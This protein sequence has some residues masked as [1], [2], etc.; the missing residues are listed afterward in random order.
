MCEPTTLFILGAAASLGGAGLS[1]KAQLDAG[2]AQAAQAKANERYAR[3]QAQDAVDRA[4]VEESIMR[5]E[6]GRLTGRQRT[7]F[8]ASGVR[9]GVGSPLDVLADTAATTEFNALTIRAGGEREAFGARVQ[10]AGFRASA[11]NLARQGR[12]GAARSLLSG[13]SSVASGASQFGQAGGFGG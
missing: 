11:G 8:A 10:A 2:K 9:L 13:A 5:R 7:A 3:W 1:A 4:A 6:A 12:L